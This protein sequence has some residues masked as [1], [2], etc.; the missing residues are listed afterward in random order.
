MKNYSKKLDLKGEKKSILNFEFEI[1]KNLFPLPKKKQ[2][3]VSSY[4]ISEK[5]LSRESKYLYQIKKK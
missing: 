3:I 4:E 1:N 2:S 5:D